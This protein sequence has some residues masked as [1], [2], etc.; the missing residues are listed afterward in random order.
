MGARARRRQSLQ[1]QYLWTIGASRT[2][3]TPHQ[4]SSLGQGLLPGVEKET[5]RRPPPS[6]RGNRPMNAFASLG[7][8]N[9]DKEEA[10]STLN[11]QYKG[12]FLPD[13]STAINCGVNLSTSSGGRPPTARV[14][15]PQILT[16]QKSTFWGGKAKQ[17]QIQTKGT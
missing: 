3:V 13:G 9:E 1:D 5:Q 8:S 2:E 4:E 11:H 16:S 12:L 7:V 6:R 15:T 10:P 17:T 14:R